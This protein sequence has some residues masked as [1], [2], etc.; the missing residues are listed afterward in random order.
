MA[1]PAIER[2]AESI[3]ESAIGGGSEERCRQAVADVVAYALEPIRSREE[4]IH[5][6]IETAL[7]V[8]VRLRDELGLFCRL[9]KL[10]ALQSGLASGVRA[11]LGGTAID[12]SQRIPAETLLAD[13]LLRDGCMGA[14]DLVDAVTTQIDSR[15]TTG[16]TTYLSSLLMQR[17]VLD[18]VDRTALER[19]VRH[20]ARMV[21]LARERYAKG[22]DADGTR[23]GVL[24][25]GALLRQDTA[26][27]RRLEGLVGAGAQGEDVSRAVIR[28]GADLGERVFVWEYL[29]ANERIT[30]ETHEH[31]VGMLYDV[32]SPPSP[33]WRLGALVVE[34]GYATPVEMHDAIRTSHRK[35]RRLGDELVL[36]G[37]IDPAE[38]KYLLEVQELRRSRT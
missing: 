14:S 6:A 20:K 5:E 10:V 27:L 38:L 9:A 19:E 30:I 35:H 33:N 16:A 36:N 4:V 28:L 3:W 34:L 12:P 23:S 24:S 31:V 18:G 29:L 13:V 21:R 37:R 7:R 1:V 32:E 17:D 22:G 11:A 15:A 8:Q 26:Y 2:L 25:Y